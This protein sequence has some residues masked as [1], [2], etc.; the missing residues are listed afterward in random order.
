LLADSAIGAEQ[1]FDADWHAILP[2]KQHMLAEILIF[3]AHVVLIG[4]FVT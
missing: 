1:N 4:T 2:Q 3:L